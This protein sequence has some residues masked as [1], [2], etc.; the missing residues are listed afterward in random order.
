MSWI[1]FIWSMTAGIC[2]TLGVV[3]SFVWIRQRDLWAHLV[4]SATAFAAAGYAVLDMVALHAQTPAEYG[5]LWRWALSLGIVE[6]VLMVWFIRLYLR[7]GRLWLLWLICGLRAIMLV[8]NFAPG[9]NFYFREL[10]GLHQMPLFGELIAQPHGVLHPWVMLMP[11]TFLLIILFAIDAARQS[12]RPGAW[13]LGGLMAVG[14]SLALVTYGLYARGVLASTFSSQLVLLLVLLMGYE[15]GRDVVRASH[16]SRSLQQSEERMRLAASATNLGLWEWDVV[17]DE[18][19]ATEPSRARVGVDETEHLDLQRFLRALH[20]ADCQTTERALRRSLENGSEFEAEYRVM[21]RDGAARWVVARG[22]VERDAAGK[23]L[24]LRGISVDITARRRSEEALRESEARFRAV[25]DAAPVMI[26]MTDADGRCNFF[27][28]GWLDFTGRRLDQELGDGWAEGVHSE[29]LAQCTKTFVECF[30]ARRSFTME[31]RLRRHDGEYRWLSNCGVPRYD[32]SQSFLG[33]IGAC[34]DLTSRRQ[35]EAETE[36][37]RTEL[38]HVTRVATMGQLASSL[39]HELNQPLGAILRNAE[40]AQLLLQSDAPDLEEIRAIL[41]DICADDHRAGAVIDR[42][43]AMLK[44]HPL[45]SS[46]FLVDDLVAEVLDLAR[47]D[48]VGRRVQLRVAPTPSLPP[49]RGD[50]VQLQQVL[51]NLILN[52]MDAMSEM[53]VEARRLFVRT[54][55]SDD[56]FV[57]IA[58]TDSGCGIPEDKL[59]QVF[60]PFFTTKPNGLGMGLAISRSIIEG[61]GGNLQAENNSDR[62]ATVRFTLPIAHEGTAQ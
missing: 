9:P 11:L 52:G 25:A 47:S 39:A 22:Q 26:W 41:A 57:E 19:W 34:V 30:N 53:P 27:N 21:A 23:A 12:G 62:G 3:H 46:T 16:L 49:V 55:R 24:R 37:Q 50:R 45:V 17:K 20:P 58:V 43:R 13:V 60:E 61:H 18:I 8:L 15:L 38:A 59:A 48:A 6:G 4:F 5:E 44:R 2:L 31:Y 10:T 14:F 1:T 32:A 7:A 40:A 51:L 54:R 42:T 28:K 36:R 35:L 56:H 33:Y 29:D